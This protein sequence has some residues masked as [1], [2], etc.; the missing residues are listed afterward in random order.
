MA[1]TFITDEFSIFLLFKCIFGSCSLALGFLDRHG[2]ICTHSS[3]LGRH[4][5]DVLALHH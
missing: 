4:R 5:C 1:E 3:T 2:W